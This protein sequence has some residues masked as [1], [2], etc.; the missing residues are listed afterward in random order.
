MQIIKFSVIIPTLHRV[1]EVNALLESIAHQAYQDLEVIIVDQNGDDRLVEIVAEYS[2]QLPIQHFRVAF[3]GA[4]KARNFGATYASGEILFFPDDDAE[5]LPDLLWQAE[6][7]FSENP[8]CDVIFGKCVDRL[9]NDSVCNFAEKSGY[10]TK[11]K[12]SGMFIEAT[13]FIKRDVFLE[14]L[15]DESLGVG[16]FHGAE[17]A[18]DLV[19]RL[20]DNNKTLY[21]TPHLRVY[22]PNKVKN[23][24]DSD[25]IRR[26]FA[27]R[28]GFAKLCLKHKLYKKLLLRAMAI[29][30]Y[31]PALALTDRKRC[32]YYFS[33][34][35]G[36]LSGIVIK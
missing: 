12:H 35:L 10:L 17:E 5:L 26:V 4:S 30:L 6:V 31:L 32:R 28:C 21:Y 22:H 27:Y 25:E 19:L 2:N 14:H 1:T 11:S 15:F 34:L 20:L 7:S 13:M 16:T 18:Y 36:L 29:C 24:Q 9:G 23:Y 8:T 3:R 33:E